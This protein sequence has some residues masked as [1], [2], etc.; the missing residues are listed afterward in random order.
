[1]LPHTFKYIMHTFSKNLHKALLQRYIPTLPRHSS[2]I[3]LLM[4]KDQVAEESP[5][6]GMM[7]IMQSPEMN[8]C[9]GTFVYADQQEELSYQLEQ[10]SQEP[11]ADQ[12]LDHFA[13]WDASHP[14]KHDIYM[15]H[16]RDNPEIVGISL[17][18]P[19]E[20]PLVFVGVRLSEDFP[21]IN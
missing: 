1:M 17:E 15:G 6:F 19:G 3:W 12:V 9:V 2:G 8:T 14:N 5:E 11:D 10:S 4:L 16:Q 18:R 7:S 21:E 20:L 13:A